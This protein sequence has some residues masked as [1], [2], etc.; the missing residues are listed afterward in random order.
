MGGGRIYN[1][2]AITSGHPI[3]FRC[4]F[5]DHYSRCVS[6]VVFVL[7]FIVLRFFFR[8]FQN[9]RTPVG[10]LSIH[11][12]YI[13]T[14][15]FHISNASVELESRT[16]LCNTRTLNNNNNAKIRFAILLDGKWSRRGL[17]RGSRSP[18][19]IRFASSYIHFEYSAGCSM[20]ENAQIQFWGNLTKCFFFILFFTSRQWNAIKINNDSV[21]IT[22]HVNTFDKWQYGL[23]FNLRIDL[24]VYLS[25][26]NRT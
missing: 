25:I 9:E 22:E 6:P 24:L 5:G 7:Y 17:P 21:Q 23:N 2:A 3:R 20:L 10:K 4:K 11:S 16:F 1:G 18:R 8:T 19:E 13:Y 12:I 26:E 14:R 15:F